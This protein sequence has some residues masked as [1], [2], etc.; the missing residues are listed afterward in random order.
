MKFNC[1]TGAKKIKLIIRSSCFAKKKAVFNVH[2][3][4]DKS[5][6]FI[7][8]LQEYIRQWEENNGD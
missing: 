1:L 7:Q 6:R 8:G 4:K 3:G 5:E 2:I